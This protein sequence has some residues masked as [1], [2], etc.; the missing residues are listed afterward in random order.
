[1]S[2]IKNPFAVALGRLGGS[3]S[4]NRKLHSSRLNAALGG[5]RKAA[6]RAARE[7]AEQQRRRD[8]LD[9]CRAECG[10]PPISSLTAKQLEEVYW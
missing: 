3:V 6:N 1:M 7:A 4:S 5:Q 10:L 2:T 9:R 8:H